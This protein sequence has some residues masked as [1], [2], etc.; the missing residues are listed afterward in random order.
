MRFKAM[1]ASAL[2]STLALVAA[3]AIADPLNLNFTLAD[4]MD[5]TV[6]ASA[7][8][9]GASNS[10]TVRKICTNGN[11]VVTLS[12]ATTHPTAVSI[13]E[14]HAQLRQRSKA[15]QVPQIT[16][17][18]QATGPV[19]FNVVLACDKIL[20]QTKVLTSPVGFK[21]RFRLQAQQCTGLNSARVAHIEAT[22]AASAGGKGAKIE[23]EG[24]TLD[25]IRVNGRGVA[26]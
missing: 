16:V 10:A 25:L 4:D 18:A 15:T 21:G 11:A 2:A 9:L 5:Q 8:H 23:F 6:T 7:G 19:V 22:C 20:V 1:G 13:G 26:N 12:G 24:D 17:R 3:S 14:D